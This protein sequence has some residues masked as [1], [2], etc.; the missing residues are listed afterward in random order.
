LLEP[1]LV[2]A[3]LAVVFG[4][5]LP[6]FIDYDQ[7]WAALTQ[8]DGRELVVLVGLELARI[9]TEALMYRAFLPGLR[10]WRGTE[11]YLSS[12]LEDRSCRLRL[13]ASFSTATSEAA[14]TRRTPPGLAALGSF[15][16]PTINRLLL[17]SSPC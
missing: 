6:Q 14:A 12:N 7:V 2:I 8:L 3:V 17:P 15:L 16:V 1:V 9:P 4:W 10:L 13:R 5:L 11:A